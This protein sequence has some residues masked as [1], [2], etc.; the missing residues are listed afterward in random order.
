M[1]KFHLAISVDNIEKSVDDYSKRI[2]AKPVVLIPQHY[3][4]WQTDTLNFSIRHD[5]ESKE[6][7][8]HLGW[9][10]ETAPQFTAEKDVNGILWE[11]FSQ[12][13]QLQEIEETWP[14]S[15]SK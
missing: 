8:R 1:K 15:E 5:A 7:L 13:Q 3:A 9:Q 14:S 12:A 11:H 4:L 6:R 2:G 10:D